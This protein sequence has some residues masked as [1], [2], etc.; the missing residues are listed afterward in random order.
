MLI[1]WLSKLGCDFRPVFISRLGAT[2][3]SHARYPNNV[4]G[5]LLCPGLGRPLRLVGDLATT[6]SLAAPPGSH[7]INSFVVALVTQH[8]PGD[9]LPAFLQEG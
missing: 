9:D 4:E 3:K 5:G 1:G 6:S 2:L 7:E 8:E